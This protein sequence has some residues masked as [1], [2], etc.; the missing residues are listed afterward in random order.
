M[1]IAWLMWALARAT[2]Y[3]G[4]HHFRSGARRAFREALLGQGEKT[5]CTL[6]A[7]KQV[8]NFVDSHMTVEVFVF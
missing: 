4:G 5:V 6:K 7:A 2:A 1:S 3:L 8:R